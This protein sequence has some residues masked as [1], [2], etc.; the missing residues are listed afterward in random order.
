MSY[1]P[2]GYTSAAPYLVVEDAQATLD[3]AKA[4]FDSEPLRV[5]R[6]DDGSIVHA[7]F[8]IDDTVIMLGQMA[9]GADANIHVYLPDPDTVFARALEAGATAVA[10]MEDKDDGDRRGGVR[11]PSGTTWWLAR[12]GG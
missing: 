9:G 5:F 8:R 10:E 2:E 3:F 11:D 12:Q 4:V 7:E 6:R 1:K